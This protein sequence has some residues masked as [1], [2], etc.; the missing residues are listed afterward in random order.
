M[1]VLIIEPHPPTCN[2]EKMQKSRRKLWEVHLQSLTRIS[3]YKA[4]K[5]VVYMDGKIY[6]SIYFVIQIS[7]IYIDDIIAIN[8]PSGIPVH[9]NIL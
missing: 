4:R 7:I 1:F 3:Q 9:G 6:I 2:F 5:M 8:K